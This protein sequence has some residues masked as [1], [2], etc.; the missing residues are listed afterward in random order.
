MTRYF[1]KKT[2]SI[3]KTKRSHN[4]V[5]KI[6]APDFSNTDNRSLVTVQN[7]LQDN[8]NSST[9]VKNQL[10]IQQQSSHS[11]LPAQLKK[12]LENMSG[13]SMD[14]VKVHYQSDKPAQLNAHAYA[15]G[16]EIHLGPGQEKHLP[17]EAWHVVQQKQ[18]RV[19][20]TI[21]QKSFSINDDPSLEKEADIM[22]G[23]ASQ[24][25]TEHRPFPMQQ[26]KRT[27]S[28][29]SEPPLQAVWVHLDDG[30][31]YVWDQLVDGLR[32][33][34]DEKLDK[35]YFNIASPDTLKSLLGTDDLKTYQDMA[36]REHMDTHDS[37]VSTEHFENNELDEIDAPA[38]E[39]RQISRALTETNL[40]TGGIDQF[41]DSYSS[42][43]QMAADLSGVPPLYELINIAAKQMGLDSVFE[44]EIRLGSPELH[45]G[46]ILGSLTSTSHEIDSIEDLTAAENAREAWK[47]R[48]YTFAQLYQ[49][50]VEDRKLRGSCGQTSDW[51]MDIVSGGLQ[52]VSVESPLLV[53]DFLKLLGS[54]SGGY[55]F[56]RVA[57]GGHSFVIESYG[58]H[59]Y[60]YQS[61]HG[62]MA[63]G[64]IL[65][66]GPPREWAPSGIIDVLGTALKPAH[67]ASQ[68]DSRRQASK[69]AFYGAQLTLPSQ[70]VW[71]T[72]NLHPG[73]PQ[74]IVK[75]IIA[76]ASRFNSRWLALLKDSRTIRQFKDNPS[77]V[78]EISQIPV[79][80]EEVSTTKM[81]DRSDTLGKAGLSSEKQVQG[82]LSGLDNEQTQITR[83]QEEE[84]R[85]VVASD[86]KLQT[87]QLQSTFLDVPRTVLL[88]AM[89]KK[90]IDFIFIKKDTQQKY[91]LTG[92]DGGICLFDE[93]H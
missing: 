35:M 20:P 34:Y 41:L 12:N 78:D 27:N 16:N 46:A 92:Y 1:E 42:A 67:G 70:L 19:S 36:G 3:E 31:L 2:T 87:Y 8:A 6:R 68:E 91:R 10:T 33:F 22:G 32:W 40:S 5:Q 4:P 21:Q 82:A 79:D 81:I 71:F 90:E 73:K 15:Q 64:H 18:G 86:L 23:K 45:L 30:S 84:S 62:K 74:N 58:S 39:I 49:H 54:L 61:W 93:T 72:M 26:V 43:S 48:N 28:S 55:W 76:S 13:H 85:P 17:H 44:L 7:K 37:W 75:K 53:D 88:K 52:E 57:S 29:S 65:A 80:E 25:S 50:Y 59:M 51:I 77:A 9:Q 60:L 83:A 69:Q 11:N 14:E 56:G 24:L 89:Q 38:A 63:L 47:L 66:D